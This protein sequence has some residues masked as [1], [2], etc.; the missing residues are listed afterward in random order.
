MHLVNVIPTILQISVLLHFIGEKLRPKADKELAQVT[1]I[2]SWKQGSNPR[3][4][5]RSSQSD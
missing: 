1:V 4:S 5:D 3:L 2:Q